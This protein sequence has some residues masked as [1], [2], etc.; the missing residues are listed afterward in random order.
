MGGM[1]VKRLAPHVL[2][3]GVLAVV[4]LSGANTAINNSLVDLRQSWFP[5]QASGEIAVVAI[6]SPSI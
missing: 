6:D 2:V 1:M 3:L 4:V 5:R